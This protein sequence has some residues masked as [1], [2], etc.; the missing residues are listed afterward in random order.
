MP[1]PFE[2]LRTAP[3]P[4]DPDPAFAARLRARVVRAL[5]PSTEGNQSM[6]LLTPETA[7]RLH[8]GDISYMSLWVH[9]LSHAISF[10]SEVLGWRFASAEIGGGRLVEGLSTSHGV[11][12]LEATRAYLAQLGLSG[13]PPPEP[14]AFLTFVVDDIRAAVDRVRAV[15]GSSGAIDERPYGSL[16]M[17]VDDQGMLFALNS[18]PPG[19]P[20]PRP[21]ALGARAGEVAYITIEAIDD[22]RAREFYAAVLGWQFTPG[23]VERGWNI[24]DVVPMSG[25]SGGHPASRVVPMYRVDDIA[26]AVARL[27]EL[28]GSASDPAAQPYGITADCY[29]GQGTRFYL[30]QF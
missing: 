5:N 24:A 1:D 21:S 26:A 13:G 8:Q 22:V 28:G 20:A 15:G 12:S 29:D 11:A 16:A 27:R 10:Y 2:A 30:G 7:E 17:C 6:T 9:D 14:T 25:L 18:L 23:R 19:P 3:T 4:I